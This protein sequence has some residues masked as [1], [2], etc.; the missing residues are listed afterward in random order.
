MKTVNPSGIVIFK[1][2][3]KHAG[4]FYCCNLVGLFPIVQ[5][6]PISGLF[7]AMIFK[8][9]NGHVTLGFKIHLSK[10]VGC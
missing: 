4:Y 10:P 1:K 6:N 7:R 9:G 8:V 5:T 3:P 2:L